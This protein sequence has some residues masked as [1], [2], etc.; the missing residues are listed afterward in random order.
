MLP[1]FL[2]STSA[3]PHFVLINLGANDVTGVSQGTVTEASWKTATNSVL[4]QLHTKWPNAQ[5]L[6][7]KVYVAP[8]G[9]NTQS[10]LLIHGWMDDVLAIKTFARLG[11]YEPDVISTHMADLLH[12]DATGYSLTAQTWQTA[13]GY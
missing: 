7:T 5:I 1:A 11:L 2:T 6:V 3:D 9:N 12:P 8:A 4:D 13:M 10:M